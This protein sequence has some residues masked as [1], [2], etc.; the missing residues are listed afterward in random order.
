MKPDAVIKHLVDAVMSDYRNSPY[1]NIGQYWLDHRKFW[2][3][4]FKDEAFDA[5]NSMLNYIS[6][7]TP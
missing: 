5:V 6:G 3:G 7:I 1:K 4:I 2:E